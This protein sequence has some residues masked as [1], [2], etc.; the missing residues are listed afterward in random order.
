MLFHYAKTRRR[1]ALKVAFNIL[2]IP[3]L[4]FAFHYFFKDKPNFPQIYDIAVK[5]GVAVMVVLTGIFLWFLTSKEKF[6]IYVTGNEFYSHHPM[7][8]EWCFSVDPMDIVEI[9]HHLRIDSSAMTN[10]N[11]YLKDGKKVQICQN[12]PFSRKKLYSALEQ[13]NPQIQFPDNP[14]VFKH[15]KSEAMDEY[16]SN[17][18]PVTTKV[19]KSALNVVPGQKYESKDR[20]KDKHH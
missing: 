6:E 13:A 3:V 4:L 14:N 10:I 11:V 7:F 18:F 16:V 8:K 19:I 5:A 20:K 12:Y 15:R 2:L 9:E 1:Q 17:R